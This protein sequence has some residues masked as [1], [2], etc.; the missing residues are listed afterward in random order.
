M[1]KIICIGKNHF[2]HAQELHEPL[3]QEPILFLKP[4]STG[5]YLETG[6]I[7]HC[8]LPSNLGPIHYECEIILKIGRRGFQASSTEA[9]Q[10]VEAISLGLDLTARD[11]QKSLKKK[12]HPWEIS[13]VFKNSAIIAPWIPLKNFP[14]FTHQEFAFYLDS[15]LKQ[16]A[17]ADEMNF[18]PWQCISHASRFFELLP[19]D[20]V[21]T[22]TPDGTGPLASGQRG[23]LL[24]GDQLCVE[25]DF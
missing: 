2:G 19:G 15:E 10:M 20:I 25:V 24:W 18:S 11:L 12:G 8:P 14:H 21:F 22:G 17:T 6:V 23:Q 1:D 3:P 7:N 4:P 9:P 5:L 13:K 16:K